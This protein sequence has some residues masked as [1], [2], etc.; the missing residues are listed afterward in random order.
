MEWMDSQET[1]LQANGDNKLVETLA[2]LI[3]L[4]DQDG[5]SKHFQNLDVA[6]SLSQLLAWVDASRFFRFLEIMDERMPNFV[7]RLVVSLGRLGGD[8]AIF[9][10][11]FF[12]RVMVVHK[13][14]LMAKLFD[15]RRTADISRTIQTIRETRDA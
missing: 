4:C 7:T 1:W 15:S 10:D 12:E 6:S 14:E 3:D 8:R 2:A 9:A 11:L 5:A 13:G